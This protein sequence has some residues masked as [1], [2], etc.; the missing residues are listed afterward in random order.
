MHTLPT[1]QRHAKP[2]KFHGLYASTLESLLE[3]LQADK[4]PHLNFVVSDLTLGA[5]KSHTVANEYLHQLG[6]NG[7][8]QEDSIGSYDAAEISLPRF[9]DSANLISLLIDREAA[10]DHVITT[11]LRLAQEIIRDSQAINKISFFLVIAPRFGIPWERENVWFVEF[12]AQGLPPTQRLLIVGS[13]SSPVTLPG[14]WVVE[15]LNAPP[16][17][18]GVQNPDLV[19]LI[20]GVINPETSTAFAA[21]SEQSRGLLRLRDGSLFVAPEFRRSPAETSRKTF[22]QL[23]SNVSAWSWLEAYA[24]VYGSPY[25]VNPGLLKSEAT[26]RFFE[27]SYDIAL[28]LLYRA[29]SRAED[30]IEGATITA[31]ILSVLIAEQRFAEAADVPLPSQALP[32]AL[33]GSLLLGKAWGLVMINKPNVAEPYFVAA[34]EL[35]KEYSS[36][37]E[38]LYLMNIYALNRLKSGDAAGALRIENE[39]EEQLA[40]NTAQDWHIRYINS[41]NTARL[42]RRRRD[43]SAAEKYYHQA[44]STNLGGRSESDRIYV[45]L[46]EASLA[47]DRG[48]CEEAFLHTF[49]AALHW[50]SSTA[51]EA[52]A[53]RVATALLRREISEAEDLVEETSDAF[54][55]VL[56]KAAYDIGFTS[57]NAASDKL[58]DRIDPN[59]VHI[60]QFTEEALAHCGAYAV[61]NS[62]WGFFAMRA[63]S[64]P[65]F[66]GE[67]YRSLCLLVYE[68]TQRLTR[69][70]DLAS[71]ETIIVDDRFGQEM[72]LTVLDLLSCCLRLKLSQMLFD[73][74]LVRLGPESRARLEGQLRVRLSNIVAELTSVESGVIV[75]FKRYF[76]P[77]L[78]RSPLA[79]ILPHLEAQPTVESIA[80]NLKAVDFDVLSALR[81]LEK[82]RVVE[83]FLNETDCRDAGICLPR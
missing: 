61:G 25:F 39:I 70:W 12:L 67:K 6:L 32:P 64:K 57:L 2:V 26:A 19:H 54:L 83:L 71:A 53:P 35:L 76:R 47:A 44:F 31:T 13:E 46:C 16:A 81:M 66:I 1:I 7:R 24:Q 4:S 37:R 72:P 41:I 68:M 58:R 3:F 36:S 79:A 38:Y 50:L 52:L 45:N 59:Y 43:Y 8:R 33:R 18:A 69:G 55:S 78:V 9:T 29:A 21:G 11:A 30:P 10:G 51:P 82:S 27:G 63:P 20:P 74:K 80:S 28:K 62:G 14:H 49:R 22:D 73:G 34:R 17:P 65:R 5:W 48:L 40:L 77:K 42:H 23:A 60:S 15:W 56:R 75:G